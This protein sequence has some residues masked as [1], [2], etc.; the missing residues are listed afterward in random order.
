[1]GRVGRGRTWRNLV[2]LGREGGSGVVHSITCRSGIRGT[3]MMWKVYV[4]TM[5]ICVTD[6]AADAN[7]HCSQ[8]IGLP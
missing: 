3:N 6:T 5:E 1:M 8:R 4:Y 7:A 2:G